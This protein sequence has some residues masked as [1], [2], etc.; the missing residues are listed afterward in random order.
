VLAFVEGAIPGGADIDACL[1]RIAP[2]AVVVTPL[3]DFNSYQTDYVK[4]A[5]HRG[6]PV[7]LAVASW[8][9]LT[10]KG[11]IGVQPDRVFVWNDAQ[12]REA[13]TLHGT[14][15]SRVQLTGAPLFDD[16]FDASPSTSREDFC[17][18]VG[19]DPGRP[20]FL[21]LCSSGFIAPEEAAFVRRW[22]QALRTSGEALLRT[23]GV[24]V[25]PHPGSAGIWQAQ[26]LSDLGNVAVWPRAGALPL[27]EDAKHGYFDSLHHSAAVVGIN[28]SGMIEAGIVGR[29]SFTVLDPAFADTQEG[30]IH[31]AHLAGTGFLS[32]ASSLEEHH[33]QLAAEVRHPS[34]RASFAAFLESFVRPAGLGQPATPILVDAIEA[35]PAVQ[36]S[37]EP[38]SFLRTLVARTAR[39]TL[40]THAQSH[41]Q[42]AQ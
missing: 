20:Y 34:S 32:L 27:D 30:T 42:T 40:I 14:P 22:L 38:R 1:A 8:D 6:I 12:R 23:C 9:N 36:S 4:G 25:R 29:R 15:A 3:V 37:R 35:L 11:V 24:L 26:D 5:R 21:Y 7:A 18:A 13:V 41:R 16:W 2:D 39:A 10:N 28:T 17:A 19:L 31:F 33:A